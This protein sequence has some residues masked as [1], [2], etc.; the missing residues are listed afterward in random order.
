MRATCAKSSAARAEQA[1]NAANAAEPVDPLSVEAA[2]AA[3]DAAAISEKSARTTYLQAKGLASQNYD[4][5]V[6]S[7]NAAVTSAQ[8]AHLNYDNAVANADKRTVTAPISGYVTT[9]SVRN[10]DQLGSSSTKSASGGTTNSSSSG[11]TPIVISDLSEL[12]AAVQISET[13]RFR[14]ALWALRDRAGLFG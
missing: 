1:L 13:G 9:L 7:Y 6:K 14:G 8:S 10:G 3:Y 2:Q 4:A 12:E 5:A 11:S